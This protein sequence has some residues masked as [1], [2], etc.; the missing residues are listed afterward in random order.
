VARCGVY[1][2]GVR[3]LRACVAADRGHCNNRIHR[4]HYTLDRNK[5]T[6]P[7]AARREGR[8][9]RGAI[10]PPYPLGSG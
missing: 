5:K 6:A 3:A 9:G 2:V 7:P 8:C 10:P 1:G 4:N